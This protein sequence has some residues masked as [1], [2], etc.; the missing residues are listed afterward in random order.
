[1]FGFI[2]LWKERWNIRKRRKRILKDIKKAKKAYVNGDERFMCYCFKHV[3]KDKYAC[4][5]DIQ[6]YIPE[7]NPTYLN[8]DEW[9]SKYSQW[10]YVSDREPRIKAFDKLIELY[11]KKKIKG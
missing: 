7:F 11:S 2:E 5:E 4:L 3:N 8:A 6:K 9:A 10:W 1:M